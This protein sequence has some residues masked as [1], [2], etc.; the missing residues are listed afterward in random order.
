M[1]NEEKR[2]PIEKTKGFLGD[3]A[4]EARKT[5][6]PQGEELRQS[7]IVVIITIAM[8]G[9]FVWLSDSLLQR[10]IEAIYNLVSAG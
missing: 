4:A 2:N 6:W 1:K 5:S 9:A 8:L 3:V 10:I 7:T